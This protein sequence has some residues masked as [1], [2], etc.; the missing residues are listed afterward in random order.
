MKRTFNLSYNL[1]GIITM[2][3]KNFWET[4]KELLKNGAR[5]EALESFTEGHKSGDAKATFGL[6]LMHY[7]GLGCR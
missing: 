7:H 5:E 1:K 3:N 2:N 6:A 4:G